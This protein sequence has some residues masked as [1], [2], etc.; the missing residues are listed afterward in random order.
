MLASG[1]RLAISFVVLGSLLLPTSPSDTSQG[2]GDS[3]S[4][5]V[6]D[7]AHEAYG[8]SYPITYEFIIPRHLDSAQAFHR[9]LSDAPWGKITEQTADAVFNGIEAVR[10][11]YEAHRA[12]V[13]LS[14]DAASDDLSLMITDGDGSIQTISFMRIARYYDNRRCAFI[15]SGDDWGVENTRDSFSNWHS[16][17][18][19][20]NIWATSALVTG[21]PDE[22]YWQSIQDEL[23]L[24][25]VEVAAHSRTH[26]HP[27][28]SDPDSEIGGCRDDIVA[29][30]MLPWQ[31]RRGTQQYV[32]GWVEPF[33]QSDTVVRAKLGEYGYLSDRTTQTILY[34]WAD[35][36]S[37]RGL[38]K[39]NGITFCPQL[40]RDA[41]FARRAFDYAYRRHLLCHFYVHPWKMDSSGTNLSVWQ[42]GSWFVSLMDYV[43]NRTDVWYVGWGAAHVYRYCQQQGIITITPLSAP[44]T[45]EPA[46]QSASPLN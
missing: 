39:R 19:N 13:S 8:L 27:P 40:A 33:G 44:Q 1:F 26:P 9:H 5:S 37:G 14:F 23:N 20:R 36:D 3:W 46:T 24:G 35:W 43:G 30:L 7:A 21:P 38:Y 28:Y 32:P 17:L 15:F 29:R 16:V 22:S 11:D 31:Y 34:N 25:N 42:S 4:I 45:H 12:Y 41:G 10:F 18:R 6:D 2:S